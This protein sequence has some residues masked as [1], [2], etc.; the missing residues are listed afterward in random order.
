VRVDRPKERFNAIIEAFEASEADISI[1][2]F[3]HHYWLS[4]YEYTTEKKLY[5]AFKKQIRTEEEA[6]AFLD[7]VE[8]DAAL[9]RVIHEPDSRKWPIERLDLRDALGA[10]GL[11]RVR[12]QLPFVLSVLREYEDGRLNL[13]QTTRALR[14]VENFHFIFTA[15]TS[16]RSSGGISFMYAHHARELRNAKGA[17]R[18]R[19][20]IDALIHKLRDKRPPYQEFE[21]NFRTILCSE[22]F[23]KRKSL[24][25][26][27]LWRMSKSFLDGFEP[28]RARMTVEHIAGQAV[29]RGASLSDDQVAEIGNLILVSDKVNV[30][31][32]DKPFQEKLA[33][34]FKSTVW[35]DEYLRQQAAWGPEQIR[36]RT[37]H[38]AY[39]A[40][41]KV[42][43]I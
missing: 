26:Y 7:S 19:E 25:Q 38:L 34:L 14:A 39:L 15:V 29:P 9:Y 10:L 42:W 23:T 35:V 32:A 3:L 22:K 11:F 36:K 6:K 24:V 40:Y 8:F 13:K 20:E 27:I 21:A 5:K 17:Q 16:Q 1:N 2:S 31:L 12:Q 18:K 43:K 33:I 30:Q 37:D 28:E 41:E 4:R